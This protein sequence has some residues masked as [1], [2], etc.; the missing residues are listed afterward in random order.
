MII[1]VANL[2]G[3]LRRSTSAAL[4]AEAYSRMGKNVAIADTSWDGGAAHW[5]KLARQSSNVSP[6]D[7]RE[8]PIEATLQAHEVVE[9]GDDIRANIQ[10]L[11]DSLGDNGIV[12]VDTNS[13]QEQALRELDSI[14]DCV[15]VPFDGS[16]VSV[17]QTRRTLLAVNKPTTLFNCR[18]MDDESR[19]REML[20]KVGVKASREANAAIAYSEDAQRCRIPD[21]M[22]DYEALAAE[23]IQ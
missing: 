16:S 12:I 1:S 9:F 18:G 2:K 11:E 13:H 19:Y 10:K 14:V 22:S 5:L 6:I 15:A 7:V 3:G 20:N 8:Y 4:L 23:L 21:N 17:T